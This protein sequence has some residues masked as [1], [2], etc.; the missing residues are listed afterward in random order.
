MLNH[1]SLDLRIHLS[2]LALLRGEY[3]VNRSRK[4][5]RIMYLLGKKA[6]TNAVTKRA[7]ANFSLA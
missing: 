7:M 3:I 2:V 1:H 6:R 5:S 4:T